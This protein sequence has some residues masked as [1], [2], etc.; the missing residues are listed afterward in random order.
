MNQFLNELDEQAKS[1][2]TLAQRSLAMAREIGQQ[3]NTSS[4][5][6]LDLIER[7]PESPPIDPFS[8]EMYM[9]SLLK[10]LN[11]SAAFVRN[12]HRSRG[13]KTAAVLIRLNPSGSLKSF[14]VLNAADQQ[15]EIAFIQSVVERAVPFATF[16]RDLLRSAKSLGM[17]I[18]IRPASASEGGFGFSRL[19]NGARC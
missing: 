9:D 15:D 8:L 3:L 16:P 13:L 11:K 6:G 1:R 10:K 14:E 17:L 4:E 2:P 7:V 18:C 5:Q 19:S 12:D